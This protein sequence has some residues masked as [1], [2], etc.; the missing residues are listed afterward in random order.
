[1][2]TGSKDD[3]IKYKC[4]LRDDRFDTSKEYEQ[5]IAEHFEEIKEKDIESLTNGHDLFEC[6]LCSFG[7][8]A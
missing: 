7:I 3:S 2:V 4:A 8:W 5:H 6:N 1:M